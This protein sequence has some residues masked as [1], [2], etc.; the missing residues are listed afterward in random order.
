MDSRL[1]INENCLS[2]MQE[3]DPLFEALKFTHKTTK[4]Q[5]LEWQE[6]V[7]RLNCFD[8][9]DICDLYLTF[10][11]LMAFKQ[12]FYAGDFSSYEKFARGFIGSSTVNVLAVRGM[13]VNV[14]TRLNKLINCKNSAV[15][16]SLSTEMPLEFL[17][18]REKA[19]KIVSKFSAKP[20]NRGQ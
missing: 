1:S 11:F 19:N 17:V 8:C 14:C 15:G 18:L 5:V 12:I 9:G 6:G 2:L 16:Q 4:G 13:L 3:L 7:I 20:R 10:H